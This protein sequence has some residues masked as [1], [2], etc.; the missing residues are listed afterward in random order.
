MTT[1]AMT[2]L[3]KLSSTFSELGATTV[4]AVTGV[5]KPATPELG[6]IMGRVEAL[7]PNAA[8]MAAKNTLAKA[9]KSTAYGIQIPTNRVGKAQAGLRA[10]RPPL[11]SQ[12]VPASTPKAPDFDVFSVSTRSGSGDPMRPK[13]AELVRLTQQIKQPV[14]PKLPKPPSADLAKNVMNIIK[15]AGVV[16]RSVKEIA[17]LQAGYRFQRN[18]Y[19]EANDS[20]RSRNFLNYEGSTGSKMAQLHDGMA[21]KNKKKASDFDP[22][23]MKWGI[24]I[25]KEH[26]PEIPLRREI[27]MDHLT[28]DPQYYTKLRKQEADHKAAV[29]A[30]KEK[31]IIKESMKFDIPRLLKVKGG[32]A[33]GKHVLDDG[34]TIMH[35]FTDELGQLKYRFS[36]LG[37]GTSISKGDI[38][39]NRHRTVG[40]VGWRKRGAFLKIAYIRH[41]GN[42][43]VV[44]SHSGKHMGTY[45]SEAGAK[46]RLQQIEYFKKQGAAKH[47]TKLSTDGPGPE[48]SKEQQGAMDTLT[49][50]GSL[51]KEVYLRNRKTLLS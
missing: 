51:E 32:L 26:T 37:E 15:G 20:M 38:V 39:R 19:A 33:E 36:E 29:K 2:L 18:P 25:E 45:D 17:E 46:H 30:G 44:Y 11:T 49:K 34:K 31:G 43:Y 28:E 35:V 9:S 12:T 24:E 23:Q 7:S 8:D 13:I 48:L 42:K 1:K 27:A 16:D 47:K 50:G 41:E 6:Q 4:K 21:E 10:S 40:S 22:Q 14:L 3:E 5:M